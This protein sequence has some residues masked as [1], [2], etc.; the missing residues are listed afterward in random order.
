L[1]QE[2]G[3]TVRRFLAEDLSKDLDLVLDNN[4]S[5]SRAAT[6]KRD[7]GAISGLTLTS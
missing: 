7:S 4:A 3:F 5:S 2:H 1:L 6:T